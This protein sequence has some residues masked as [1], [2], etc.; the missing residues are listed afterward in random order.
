MPYKAVF[1][2]IGP[3]LAFAVL[4]VVV[5][6][7]NYDAVLAGRGKEILSSYIGIP[8]FLGL[9]LVHR[10]VTKSR[11]VPLLDMDLSGPKDVEGNAAR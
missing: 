9:W 4:I 8:I 10:H 3:L 1:F 5:A 2:P 11:V 6:G 7:Q